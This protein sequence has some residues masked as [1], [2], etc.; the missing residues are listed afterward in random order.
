VLK[1]KG[2]QTK[3]K[4][5]I[6]FMNCIHI[7]LEMLY[8]LQYFQ[9][10]AVFDS[11]ISG[12][13]LSLESL[14]SA[15]EGG[16]QIKQIVDVSFTAIKSVWSRF[17]NLKNGESSYCAIIL[18]KFSFI[19]KEMCDIQRIWLFET[20]YDILDTLTVGLVVLVHRFDAGYHG[21]AERSRQH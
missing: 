4:S 7:L 2:V 8:L 1:K 11:W 21:A 16:H 3:G 20:K 18:K 9:C 5:R 19:G 6:K 12:G 17:S 15:V 14:L 10:Y 13:V